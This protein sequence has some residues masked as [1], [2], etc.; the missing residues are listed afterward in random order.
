MR[1]QTLPVSLCL[2]ISLCV[3]LS[4]SLYL[5]RSP[6]QSWVFCY[7]NTKWSKS[8]LIS[9]FLF[10][11]ICLPC[12]HKE[13]NSWA[14]GVGHGHFVQSLPCSIHITGRSSKPMTELSRADPLSKDLFQPHLFPY[15]HP[16]SHRGVLPVQ[17]KVMLA[18]MDSALSQAPDRPSAC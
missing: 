8:V 4:V 1:C 17:I 13:P 11:H 10:S 6:F 15:P 5:S 9:G 3:S 18:D 16:P 12:G 7:R 14:L 2:C